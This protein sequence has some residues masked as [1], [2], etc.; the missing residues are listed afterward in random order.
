MQL[1]S[2]S[3]REPTIP[4]LT[5]FGNLTGITK[6]ANANNAET[7]TAFKS[8][9]ILTEGDSAEVLAVA[10]LCVVGCD[11][12]GVFLLHSKLLNVREVMHNQF[13]KNEEIQN[14][15]KIMGLQPTRTI[16]ISQAYVLVSAWW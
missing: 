13:M 5:F 6:L 14:I 12:F 16:L 10:G 11:N 9:L 4:S 2:N 15:K 1:V 7:R 8:M 3:H